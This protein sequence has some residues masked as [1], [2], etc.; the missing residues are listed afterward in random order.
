VLSRRH[1]EEF[2]VR[3]YFGDGKDYLELC[4][5]RAYLD[6]NR[7]LHGI[8]KMPD[9]IT[10]RE[11]VSKMLNEALVELR[12]IAQIIS[13]TRQFDQWHKTTCESIVRAFCESGYHQLHIGQ[14]Q[15]W[16][17]MTLKYIYTMGDERIPGYLAFY[18]FCHVPL[19]NIIIRA[20]SAYP[21]CPRLRCP[22]SR[23]NDYGSYLNIQHWIRQRFAL[24]PLDVEFQLWMGETVPP[25]LEE[26]L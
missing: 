8:G 25:Q 13:D 10:V 15:K 11:H 14:A 1:Y 24:P 5:D 4:I 3:L 21:D 22:W 17:N 18:G 7:T 6:F 2:L 19:D 12:Q 16:L 23:I 9:A 20:L 26:T